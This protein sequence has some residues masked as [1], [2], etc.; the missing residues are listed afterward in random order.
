MYEIWNCNNVLLYC[1]ILKSN[2]LS[3]TLNGSLEVWICNIG[4][5]K[6]IIIP[7]VMQTFQMLTHFITQYQKITF[8]WYYHSSHQKVTR[9]HHIKV[10]IK[11][12]KISLFSWKQIFI[13]ATNAVSG[14]FWTWQA[15]FIPAFLRPMSAKTQD[16]TGQTLHV[17]ALH[18]RLRLPRADPQPVLIFDDLDSSEESGLSIL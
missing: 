14:F 16:P 7:W 15:C 13:L 4:H 6:K 18:L 17:V 8:I 9:S 11:V 5:L 1:I 3:W 10:W 2:G 12:S